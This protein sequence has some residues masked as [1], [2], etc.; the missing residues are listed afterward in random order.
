M[1]EFHTYLFPEMRPNGIWRLQTT[2]PDVISRMRKRARNSN[3]WRVVGT[4]GNAISPWLF[5]CE[6]RRSDVA[7]DSLQR[8]L[9]HVGHKAPHIT[10]MIDGPGW[11]FI[12]PPASNEVP[13]RATRRT[14]ATH[15]TP[16]RTLAVAA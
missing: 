11:M 2:D 10:R 15:I 12:T 8:I 7:R 3:R 13:K 1:T 5:A 14:S 6:Y 9:A 16:T 4:P